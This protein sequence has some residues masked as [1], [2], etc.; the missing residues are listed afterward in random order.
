MTLVMPFSAWSDS[1]VHEFIHDINELEHDNQWHTIQPKFEKSLSDMY[2]SPNGI[3]QACQLFSEVNVEDLVLI[4]N[5]SSPE[6]LERLGLCAQTASLKVDEYMSRRKALLASS[7]K[8]LASQKLTSCSTRKSE[9]LGPTEPLVINPAL[10]GVITGSNYE[11][12]TITLT[13][14]DGPKKNYTEKILESLAAQDTLANFFVVGRQVKKFPTL[15]EQTQDHGHIIG[16]HTLTHP[17]LNKISYELA[18]KEIEEGFN[19]I[20][21]VLGESIPFFRF[22]YGARTRDLR[23]YLNTTERVEFLWNIDTRDWKLTDPVELYSYSLE[24]INKV[25]RG[26]ILMHDVH[27]QT[28]TAVPYLLEALREAGYKPLLAV[29]GDVLNSMNSNK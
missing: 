18:V 2:S 5:S 10:G 22:P 16:N 9:L 13:F 7:F 29:P 25:K 24:Q 20:F 21:K 26:V 28:V 23:S 27:L 14:D 15:L 19:E 4:L 6:D 3:L 12:C 11:L 17:E 8:E 1:A